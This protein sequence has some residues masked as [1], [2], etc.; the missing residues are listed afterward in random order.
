MMTRAVKAALAAVQLGDFGERLD[1]EDLWSQRLSGGEQQR[2]AVARALLTKPDWLFLDESTSALDEASE[3]LL[4]RALDEYLPETTIVSIGHRSALG[5]LHDRRIEMRWA[6][7]RRIVRANGIANQ[8]R[9]G[10][11]R[12]QSFSRKQA[13]EGG[14]RVSE[15]RMRVILRPDPASPI[16]H[17]A[18]SSRRRDNR[19][20]QRRRVR[21]R[22]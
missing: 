16:A 22:D 18:G 7:R 2:L 1:E 11:I 21:S 4:Y 13:G 6:R 8:S 10:G 5:A 12:A 3:A 17:K 19:A 15:G 20:R 9:G 14:P